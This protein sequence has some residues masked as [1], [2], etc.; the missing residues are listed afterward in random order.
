M[1]VQDART[2][3]IRMMKADPT[4]ANE[5]CVKRKS[6]LDGF[7]A[8]LNEAM[9][10][11]VGNDTEINKYHINIAKVAS[12]LSNLLSAH[13]AECQPIYPKIGDL[14]DLKYHQLESPELEMVPGQYPRELEGKPVLLTMTPGVKCKVP[15][16][17]WA[18]VSRAHV[19][20]WRPIDATAIAPNPK[21]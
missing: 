5:F 3:I 12:D 6:R 13:R 16:G 4:D 10:S 19:R 11:L 18:V 17:D 9:F 2:R 21:E 8:Q 1:I 14:F 15:G 20:L 7:V